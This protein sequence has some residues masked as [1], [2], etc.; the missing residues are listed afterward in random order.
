MLKSRM[1]EH[2]SANEIEIKFAKN[3][4]E[5]CSLIKEPLT[6]RLI[7]DLSA[8]PEWASSFTDIL[9]E[10][11]ES[12]G[13]VAHVDLETQKAAQAAGFSRVIP[14]SVLVRDLTEL[15]SA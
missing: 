14:R 2:A 12:I 9:N 6:K 15:L 13:V 4:A 1:K 8:G 7:V 10:N 3:H 5:L 11:V